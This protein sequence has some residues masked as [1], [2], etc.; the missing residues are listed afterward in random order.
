MGG[1]PPRSP[2]TSGPRKRRGVHREVTKGR[3]AAMNP[4][5]G[6]RRRQQAR[7]SG[8]VKQVVWGRKTTTVAAPGRLSRRHSV[9]RF[10]FIFAILASAFY[11]ITFFAPFC[12]QRL[13]PSSLRFT[14]KLAG[15]ALA[16]LGQEITV[17]DMSVSSPTF[18]VRIAQ[19]CNAVE[20]ITLFACAVLAFPSPFLRKIPGIV[21][22]SLCLAVLNCVRI[23]SLFLIGV[24]WPGAF[25]VMHVDVWQGV[26]VLFALVLWLLWLPWATQGQLLAKPA[27]R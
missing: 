20:P 16:R 1:L 10:L 12:K 27:S 2:P 26:F 18:S 21:V 4:R 15:A 7:I 25:R 23:V 14:A 3:A 6:Q 19:G 11:A 8:R 13:V 17:T 9:L 24:Y 5:K 22:G